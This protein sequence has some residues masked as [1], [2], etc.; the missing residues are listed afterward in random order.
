MPARSSTASI[1]GRF[2]D[3]A[4]PSVNAGASRSTASTA[5]SI[6]GSDSR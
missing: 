4:T 6:S 5:P 1:S 3:E 2:E